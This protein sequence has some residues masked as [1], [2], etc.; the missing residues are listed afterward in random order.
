MA[1]QHKLRAAQIELARDINPDPHAGLL[2]AP[3][4]KNQRSVTSRF[5]EAA[6]PGELPI[7]PQYRRDLPTLTTELVS[8]LS[9]HSGCLN[10]I[11]TVRR[12][13]QRGVRFLGVNA[14]KAKNTGQVCDPSVPSPASVHTELREG[15]IGAF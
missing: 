13:E 10:I 7:D 5:L 4:F 11:L 3:I 8:D 1:L 12:G 2:L 15:Q 14:A 6:R 9:H